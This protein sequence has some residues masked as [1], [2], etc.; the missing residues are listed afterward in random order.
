MI[1]IQNLNL[2][3]LISFLIIISLIIY[4]FCTIMGG[5]SDNYNDKALNNNLREK[6][7]IEIL[8]KKENA[9]VDENKQPEFL[10]PNEKNDES[11]KENNSIKYELLVIPK[12][13]SYPNNKNIN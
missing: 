4:Y 8:N 12:S 10:I 5:F 2:F 6:L 9:F 7:K 3:I 13:T 11:K 1:L